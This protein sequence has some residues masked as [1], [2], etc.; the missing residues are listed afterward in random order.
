[1]SSDKLA[2]VREPMADVDFQLQTEV[3]RRQVSL[4][5]NKEEMKTLINHLESANKVSHVLS[6]CCLIPTALAARP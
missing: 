4:E 3:G 6:L 5:L 1:M 2:S